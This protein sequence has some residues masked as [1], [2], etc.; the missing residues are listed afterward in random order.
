MI[1]KI[2]STAQTV[3]VAL[4]VVA[5]LGAAVV[6]LAMAGANHWS[7][8]ASAMPAWIQAVGSI[9]AILASVALIAW[10]H[11][12][13]RKAAQETENTELA[14]LVLATHLLGL[15]ISRVI[16]TFVESGGRNGFLPMSAIDFC[17]CQLKRAIEQNAH[18][19]HWKMDVKAAQNWNSTFGL[20]TLIEGSLLVVKSENGDS[21][22]AITSGVAESSLNWQRMLGKTQTECAARYE[23]LTGEAIPGDL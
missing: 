12:R 17:I 9:A 10:D 21:N 2:L 3:V 11:R 5:L 19:P 14:N 22:T 4:V 6:G 8:P 23:E 13:Q 18:T 20:A 16:H 15:S 7:G 1:S